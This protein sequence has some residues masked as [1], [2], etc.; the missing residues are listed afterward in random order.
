MI[1]TRP[2]LRLVASLV[3]VAAAACSSSPPEADPE[4]SGDAGGGAQGGAGGGDVDTGGAGG[5]AGGGGSGAPGACATWVQQGDLPAAD[6]TDLDWLD[7][8]RAFIVGTKGT[9]INTEDGGEHWTKV[10]VGT[11]DNLRTVDFAPA[12]DQ[13]IGWVVAGIAVDEY[14]SKPTTIRHTEDGGKSWKPQSNG[15]SFPPT[16]VRAIDGKRAWLMWGLGDVHPDGHWLR[17][18]NGGTSWNPPPGDFVRP[19]R[20]MM[21][22]FFTDAKNGW[23]VGSN[24]TVE[25]TIG[26]KPLETPIAGPGK[27]DGIV[28]TKDGGNSWELQKTDISTLVYFMGVTFVDAT[29]GWVVGDEGLIF[30]TEDG[31]GSWKTQK[32]GVSTML[33]SVY[34][35]DADTGWAVGA[36]GVILHTGDGGKTWAPEPSGVT[37][38][39]NRVAPGGD[40]TPWVVGAGGVVLK[41]GA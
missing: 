32:S 8:E 33:R 21:D 16:R 28:H 13:N 6:Y 29:R 12:P 19:G 36:K 1:R 34:F 24:T 27:L 38:D 26:G 7:A 41:C 31:G 40:G 9:A 17:T 11:S 5:E 37:T 35:A 4:G 18:S 10:S 39:L 25:I 30:G 2:S 23:A 20:A 15:I 22:V 3:L 14:N